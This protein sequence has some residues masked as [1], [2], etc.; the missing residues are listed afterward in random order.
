MSDPTMRKARRLLDRAERA[1]EPE[2][3]L[4][5]I[6]QAHQLLIA[7]EEQTLTRTRRAL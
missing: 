7:S 5:Y 2:E 1:R 6:R 3:R 4:Y